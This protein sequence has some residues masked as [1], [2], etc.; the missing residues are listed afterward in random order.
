VNE[1]QIRLL[2][3]VV[4]P[5]TVYEEIPEHHY[6]GRHHFSAIISDGV[7]GFRRQSRQQTGNSRGERVL[8]QGEDSRVDGPSQD[9]HDEELP[10]LCAER[11]RTRIRIR[12]IAIPREVAND[13]AGERDGIGRHN[14]HPNH[15]VHQVENAK[16]HHRA[17]HTNDGEF[18]KPGEFLA[19]GRNPIAGCSRDGHGVFLIAVI[20]RVI[21]LTE[22]YHAERKVKF[23]HHCSVFPRLHQQERL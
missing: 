4:G 20:S 3:V 17:D 5:E 10:Q 11:F 13:S 2:N 23:A 8:E 14:V 9:I 15:A 1:T 21:E 19:V 12:P 6:A 16:I 22:L 7:G 18:Q